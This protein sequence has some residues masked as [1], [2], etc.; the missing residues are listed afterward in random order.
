MPRSLPPRLGGDGAGLISLDLRIEDIEAIEVYRPGME[1]AQ[2]ARTDRG[3]GTVLIWTRAD[4]K[5][6]APEP[7]G[8]RN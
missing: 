5:A 4:A 8:G 1:P 7:S 2:F 3:C 6:R